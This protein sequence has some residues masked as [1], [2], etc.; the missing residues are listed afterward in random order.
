MAQETTGS[1]GETSETTEA[2]L[3][4]ETAAIRLPDE[5]SLALM[6]ATEG[7]SGAEENVPTL[8]ALGAAEAEAAEAIGGPLEAGASPLTR[9]LRDNNVR[10]TGYVIGPVGVGIFRSGASTSPIVLPIGQSLPSTDIVLTSLE[11]KEAAFSQANETAKLIL[12]F[13]R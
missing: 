11:G 12:D 9:Y 6:P 1:T 8:L 13:R 5:T 2:P 4:T 10:F 3:P 7:S